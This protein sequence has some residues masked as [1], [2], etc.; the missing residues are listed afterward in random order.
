MR[1]IQFLSRKNIVS[2]E[3]TGENIIE[4]K[5]YTERILWKISVA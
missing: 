3:L 4:A 2:F 1:I 5:Y